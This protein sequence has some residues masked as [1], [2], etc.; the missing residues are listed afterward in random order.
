MSFILLELGLG[1]TA[2]NVLRLSLEISVELRRWG[3][4]N[5]VVGKGSYAMLE[6]ADDAEQSRGC[7]FSCEEFGYK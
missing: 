3:R 6:R 1:K 4:N 7:G 5:T 2:R